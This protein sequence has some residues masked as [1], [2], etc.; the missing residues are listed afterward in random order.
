M[1]VYISLMISTLILGIS[2]LYFVYMELYFY[3][4][5]A[6]IMLTATSL[7]TGIISLIL[8]KLHNGSN[9]RTY[10]N[11]NA[12]YNKTN[13]LFNIFCIYF[14]SNFLLINTVERDE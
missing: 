7:T 2:A 4:I 10:E 12:L 3:S 5:I 1:K 11:L 6:V 14:D 8:R 9:Y 13:E